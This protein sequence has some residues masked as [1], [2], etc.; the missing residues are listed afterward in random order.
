MRTI[1]SVTVLSLIAP[2]AAAADVWQDR[3]IPCEPGKPGIAA[4][5]SSSRILYVSDCK[6]DG[7]PVTRSS[8]DSALNNTSSI[9]SANTRMNAYMHSDEHFAQVIECV[10]ATMAP[11]D[12]QVTTEDPGPGVPHFEVMTAGTSFE[13]NPD[14][15]GAG[16]IAPFI[17]CSANRNNVLSFVFANQTSNIDYL[18]TAIVHEAGHTYGLSHTLYAPDPMSYKELGAYQKEWQNQAQTC[19]IEDSDPQRCS[20]FS[21]QQNTFRALREAFGLNP[22]LAPAE[23]VITTPADGAYV[24]GGFPIAA[25]F[26]TPLDSLT[27]GM[28]IDSGPVQPPP[29]GFLAWNAPATLAPGPH[30][31]T[32]AGT[33]FADRMASQSVQVTVLASCADGAACPS[34]T[35]CLG[36]TCLPG[37][38]VA[39]GLGASCATN[40]ECISGSC[41]TAGE[42]S[43]CTGACDPDNTCPS[44]FVCTSGVCWPPES[45]GC[46]AG[47]G[48]PAS[49]LFGLA[50]LLA[51]RRRRRR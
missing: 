12:I 2:A 10:R 32:V 38:D 14:I 41:G 47:G 27:I 15:Q 36:G 46:N 16:G 48:G 22:Q 40:E 11:F 39:G 9:A 5:T 21:G 35:A 13:L 17:N 31:I 24:K 20:C 26:D 23:M 42:T 49:A 6:P 19:G 50:G 8:Q 37:A 28:T 7:C 34:G 29:N 25:R 44:G 3:V 18:C 4:L 30:T 1:W 51:L 43:L 33:D 45:G